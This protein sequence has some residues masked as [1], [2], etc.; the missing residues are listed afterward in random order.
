[1]L[2]S[3][4]V[5]RELSNVLIDFHLVVDVELVV[6][7]LELFLAQSL[8]THSEVYHDLILLILRQPAAH[9]GLSFFSA[10]I[11]RMSL[12]FSMRRFASASSSLGVLFFAP[13]VR[14]T[15]VS[16]RLLRMIFLSYL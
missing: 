9:F 1:M 16:F 5:I 8:D 2:V 7:L 11:F 14:P 13:G 12:A 15:V 3:D 10:S 6:E 4:R